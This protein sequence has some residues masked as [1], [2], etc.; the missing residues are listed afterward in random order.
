LKATPEPSIEQNFQ[1]TPPQ[2]QADVKEGKK[3]RR[4][5]R[6]TDSASQSSRATSLIGDLPASKR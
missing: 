6:N 2:S 3:R 1:I 5:S 4:Q